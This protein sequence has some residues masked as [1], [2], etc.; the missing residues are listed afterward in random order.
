[1]K[2]IYIYID[3]FIEIFIMKSPMKLYI[4]HFLIKKK[5]KKN[6]MVIYIL[7]KYIQL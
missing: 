4:F 5:K 6:L 7:N 2:C 1:M 3:I